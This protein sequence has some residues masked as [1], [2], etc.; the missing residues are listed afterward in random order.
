MPSIPV[1][2]GTL[3]YRIDGPAE[4][5]PLLLSNSL[6]TTLAMWDRQIPAL[7]RDF[8]VI[9]YDSRGHGRSS[10]P[11]GPYTIEQMG[12]DALALLDELDLWKVRF[13]GLSMGGMVGQWLAINA[14]ERLE[15][16]VLC[17]TAGK[18]P[19]PP[20][21]WNQRIATVESQ[22]MAPI[23]PGLMERWFT[24]AFRDARPEA[25]API[26]Q[27]LLETDP[28]GY[29]ASVAAVRDVDL[30]KD[31]GQVRVPAL[32]V[33]G[34]A[35]AATTPAQGRAIA[36]TIPGARSVTLQAAHLSNI[37]AEAEF[38]AAVTAF[39]KEA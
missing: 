33:I 13:V 15:R 29:T 14:P 12:R 7:S 3:N 32:V 21:L 20:D 22:G 37:E 2:G 9:R 39:L 1:E 24:Q 35:D 38:N 34:A 4:A 17:N 8:R 16:A 25:A 27:Q 23:V 26:R 6:G 10:V 11:P 30:L 36:D 19:G 31:L 28:R 5:P 18:F